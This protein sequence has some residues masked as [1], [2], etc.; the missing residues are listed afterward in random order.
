MGLSGSTHIKVGN[1]CYDTTREYRGSGA[2]AGLAL[3]SSSI[4]GGVATFIAFAFGKNDVA[5]WIAG[6]SV[7]LVIV[8]SIDSVTY[9]A[10][11]AAQYGTKVPCPEPKPECDEAY[12]QLLIDEKTKSSYPVYTCDERRKYS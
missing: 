9:K 1:S 6:I 7:C 12:K 5:K 8:A 3:S 10:R 2:G 4:V 11:F